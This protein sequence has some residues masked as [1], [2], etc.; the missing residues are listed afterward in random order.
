MLCW[1]T[2]LSFIS[3]AWK[4]IHGR[5]WIGSVLFSLLSASSLLHH[6]PIWKMDWILPIDIAV[7]HVS[8]GWAFF[9]GIKHRIFQLI[10]Y[11]VWSP[12]AFY[13]L[14]PKI[15]N[16]CLLDMCH[17]TIHVTSAYAF[18]VALSRMGP[19]RSQYATI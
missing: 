4:A 13:V 5:K 10:P 6:N 15:T 17:A 2:S 11:G 1:F 12:F 7:A 9:H 8:G 3:C 16:R 18:H 14:E 19:T